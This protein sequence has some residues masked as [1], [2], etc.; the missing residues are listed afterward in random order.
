MRAMI[1]AVVRAWTTP[2]ASKVSATSATATVAV[3]TGIGAA[4]V[5][6]RRFRA[7]SNRPSGRSRRRPEDGATAAR[8]VCRLA[9]MCVIAFPRLRSSAAVSVSTAT[10]AAVCCVSACTTASDARSSDATSVKPG[11]IAVADDPPALTRLRHRGAADRFAGAGRVEPSDGDVHVE[12]C[13]GLR[14][15][16]VEGASRRLF[17][18]FD[19]PR[20][21]REAM[22]YVDARHSPHDPARGAVFQAPPFHS[23]PPCADHLRQECGARRRLARGGELFLQR[24]E[25]SRRAVLERFRFERREISDVDRRW[26]REKGRA[27]RPRPA[28]AP[29]N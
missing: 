14:L 7:E 3:A 23:Q 8:D 29:I 2:P 6:G 5:G 11:L 9:I 24:R 21:V 17:A 18:R 4:D 26:R 1:V 19:E 28:A 15:V 13:G 20:L 12:A 25:L 10:C 27:Q 22:E 16:A